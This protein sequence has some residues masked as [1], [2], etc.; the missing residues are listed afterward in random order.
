MKAFC[1]ISSPRPTPSWAA[2]AEEELRREPE[3]FAEK[4][5]APIVSWGK[6][7]TGKELWGQNNGGRG[8]GRGFPDMF[9]WESV[10]TVTLEL[11]GLI[12]QLRAPTERIGEGAI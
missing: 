12:T 7:S 4:G 9:I 8:S 2:E 11:R 3:S 5:L 6:G 10:K 1:P